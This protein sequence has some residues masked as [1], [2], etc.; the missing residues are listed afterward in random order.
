MELPLESLT[1][2]V[3]V[4]GGLP[5]IGF[6]FELAS[7]SGNDHARPSLR[8]LVDGDNAD[9]IA[10]RHQIRIY[11]SSIAEGPQVT[12]VLAA[13]RHRGGGAQAELSLEPGSRRLD[14]A[15]LE[16]AAR[17]ADLHVVDRLR[18]EMI[19]CLNAGSRVDGRVREVTRRVV[20]EERVANQE[21]PGDLIDGLHR[22]RCP[23]MGREKPLFSLE[24]SGA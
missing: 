3:E 24:D 14:I 6:R 11:H 9:A 17:H 12:G 16:Q 1:L 5:G 20:L 21:A 22:G 7:P 13:Q 23:G 19:F 10:K 15:Y 2:K 8:R 4:G 18:V